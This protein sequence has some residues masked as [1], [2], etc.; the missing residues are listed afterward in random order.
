MRHLLLALF[1]ALAVSLQAQVDNYAL[2]F[3]SDDGVVN[4]GSISTLKSTNNYTL[5]MWIC[6]STWTQGAALMRCG[7]FSIKLG[8]NHAIVLNDGTNHFSVTSNALDV[9]KWTHL[10][11]RVSATDTKVHI[12]N[13]AAAAYPDRLAF[14]CETSSIWLGGNYKGRIDEVRVWRTVLPETY[15]AYWRTTLNS[16]N[17]SWNSL[18]AYWKMD[19]EQ[20][21]NLVDYRAKHHGTLSSTGVKKE[22]VTDNDKFKYLINLA[23]GNIERYFDRTID[24][25]HYWLSNRI[26]IIAATVNTDQGHANL[27]TSLDNATLINGATYLDA[28]AK[29]NGVLSLP[30]AEAALSIPAGII[31]GAERY[32]FETWAYIETWAEGGFIFRKENAEGTQ[33]ISL[34]LGSADTKDLILRHNGTDYVYASAGKAGAWMHVGFSPSGSASSAKTIFQLEVNGST[35]SVSTTSR[36]PSNLSAALPTLGVKATVGEGIVGKFDET[37]LFSNIRSTSQMSADRN[38]LPLPGEDKQMAVEE[39]YYMRALYAYDI[40]SNP[41]FDS[42]SVQGF[43]NKMRSYTKG[44]RGVKF[45]VTVAANNFESCL[46]NATKRASLAKDIANIGNDDAFDGVDIDFEWTYSATGWNNIALMCQAI[47]SQLKPG[48]ILSVSPHKVAYAFP[49]DKMNCVDYFNFQCYGPGDRDLCSQNGFTNASNL[50]LKHGYPKDKIVLSYSTTTTSGYRGNT[51]DASVAP[52]GYRYIYPGDNYDPDQDFIHNDAKDVDYWIAGWNQVVWR[53]Q[54]V[55]DNDLG[56]IMYWDLGNDLESTHK[57]SMA[58]GATYALASNVEELVTSVTG[59]ACSPADDTAAPINTPDPDDQ[60][61]DPKESETI[62]SLDKVTNT[63][64]YTLTNA[65]G[66]GTL[67]YNGTDDLWLGSSSN[68]NFSQT[69]DTES[70]AAQW[71]LIKYAGEYYLYNLA[72]GKF[73]E[74][75]KFNVTSQASRF[76]ETATPVEV[77]VTN[78]TFAFRTYTSEEKGY[79]CASPQ[80]AAHPVCQWTLNDAGSQWTLRTAPGTPV[81]VYLNDALYKID[82]TGIATPV[83]TQAED[84]YDLSGRRVKSAHPG[85][86]ITNGQKM[87]RR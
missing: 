85:L 47:R 10:T 21:P 66:L 22:K 77:T 81:A 40:E 52:A 13:V 68:A 73:V 17:P 65:N 74:V 84:I 24:A 30:T 87:L 79:L 46:A 25:R 2:R 7:T 48:K 55:V 18:S 16:L 1:T 31:D 15:N 38:S 23:Y 3:T 26:S 29:R 76:V 28:F 70:L 56:G 39:Y 12:N 43:F 27:Y 11:I 42:F 63:M 20:C 86:Y 4:L 50:F 49:T 75:T 64:A 54:Y 83:S 35:K 19:Q 67:Y 53:S 36:T 80:L 62:T 82:P 5:Q 6:P 57:H 41:G 14:P 60:G 59:A 33:G 61:G 69:V 45:T 8:R 9:N 71:L 32:T 58:R 44:M 72:C 51:R 37:M 78:G 34:R